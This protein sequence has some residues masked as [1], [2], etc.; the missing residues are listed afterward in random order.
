MKIRIS[1][2]TF[3]LMF[4]ACKNRIDEISVSEEAR[5]NTELAESKIQKINSNLFEQVAKNSGIANNVQ[6]PVTSSAG[7]I[8]NPPHGEPGHR[9]DIAVGAPLPN[10]NSATQT[11]YKPV[12]D[13][14]ALPQVSTGDQVAQVV[15]QPLV[16]AKGERLN[17]PHGEPGHRCDIPV[18]AP[19]SSK[20]AN[21][22]TAANKQPVATPQVTTQKVVVQPQTNVVTGVTAEGFSGKPNPPHG[23]P[24][25]RCDIAV[26]AILP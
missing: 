26:G 4:F 12:K 22:T 14:E 10:T 3:L 15:S 11:N 17:P 8:L 19:L 25:H 5:A 2:L 21:A 13:G 1:I 9:C 16:N 6:L 20:P 18:G 23:E 7:V 24:G